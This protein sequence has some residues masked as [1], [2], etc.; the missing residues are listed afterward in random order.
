MAM[1]A[2]EIPRVRRFTVGEYHRMREA[3]ILDEDDRVELI[4]GEVV[5]IAPIGSR[6][7]A[8]VDK[9]AAILFSRLSGKVQV[10]IQSPIRLDDQTE[11]EPDVALLHPKANAYADAHPVPDDVLLVVEVSDVTLEYDRA[12]K[13]PR[14]ASGGVPEMW[15]INLPEAYVEVH[16]RP[17]E[18]SYREQLRYGRGQSWEPGAFPGIRLAVEEILPPEQA[19]G[20][21]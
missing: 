5:Q 4:D 9:L 11:P 1:D 8:C 3:G 14:Y 18:G 2:L 12:V 21:A 7:A 17:E 19:S 16:R 15:I 20:K 10:R 13:A 6:H